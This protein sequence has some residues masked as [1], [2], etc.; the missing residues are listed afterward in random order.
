MTRLL[1]YPRLA[2]AQVV[3]ELISAP[4]TRPDFVLAW[5]MFIPT[6]DPRAQTWPTHLKVWHQEDFFTAEAFQDLDAALTRI[7]RTWHGVPA[8]ASDTPYDDPRTLL[9]SIALLS[10]PFWGSILP[11]LETLDRARS[12]LGFDTMVLPAGGSFYHDDGF[13]DDLVRDWCAARRVRFVGVRTALRRWSALPSRHKAASHLLS[14]ML[15]RSRLEG[16]HSSS[17]P[18]I[19]ADLPECGLLSELRRHPEFRVLIRGSCRDA[20]PAVALRR[21]RI[22][23][24]VWQITFRVPV[25]LDVP[26]QRTWRRWPQILNHHILP[27]LLL[28]CS[29]QASEG[30]C[31]P[32]VYVESQPASPRALL[33]RH[34]RP[35][36]EHWMHHHGVWNPI[37]AYFPAGFR[38][39]TPWRS[40]WDEIAARGLRDTAHAADDALLEMLDRAQPAP[41]EFVHDVETRMRNRKHLVVYAT[42]DQSTACGY[43]TPHDAE[44]ALRELLPL[45]ADRDD[46]V[47][48]FK[49]HPRPFLNS[50]SGR[51]AHERQIP[52]LQ[53]LPDTHRVI[54]AGDFHAGINRWL[55]ERAA[56]VMNGFSS[57]VWEALL[58]GVPAAVFDPLGQNYR[59]PLALHRIGKPAI[60]FERNAA[61]M[62]EEI[63]TL[64]DRPELLDEARRAAQQL[65]SQ[66]LVRGMAGWSSFTVRPDGSG[67]PHLPRLE[68]R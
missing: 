2:P 21:L 41:E 42:S 7:T 34:R 14:A 22:V 29:D 59:Y 26:L 5:G 30:S 57:I 66:L 46:T 61:I 24:K 9:E 60:R 48:V 10:R 15:T 11:V 44:R 64:L 52:F 56:I 8:P 63:N 23:L 45:F 6:G 49:L 43:T 51:G 19:V 68:F 3:D 17:A 16:D 27:D 28:A 62:R 54:Y 18:A 36:A 67:L 53:S 35:H 32:Q 47:W 25:P 4:D 65:K 39:L 40:I 20:S 50:Y 1:F 55:Y 12:K 38:H 37:Y 33:A 58:H 31:Q 13:L